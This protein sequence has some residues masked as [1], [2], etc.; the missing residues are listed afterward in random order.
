[1]VTISRKK[2]ELIL[3]K[4]LYHHFLTNSLLLIFLL[5]DLVNA[6]SGKSQTVLQPQLDSSQIPADGEILEVNRSMVDVNL[7]FETSQSLDERFLKSPSLIEIRWQPEEEILPISSKAESILTQPSR[8]QELITSP[9]TLTE[10]KEKVGISEASDLLLP[11]TNQGEAETLYQTQEFQ[12]QIF[13]EKIAQE[14]SEKSISPELERLQQDF[15]LDEPELLTI[16]QTELVASPTVSIVNPIAFGANLGQIFGGFGFQAR[17]RYTNSADGALGVGFG[18][19]DSQR[20]VGFD[21][22]IAV[23]SLLGDDSFERGGIS[24]KMHRLLPESFAI[25]VG[26]ENGVVWGGTDGGQ[27]LY[28]TV[29]KFFPLKDNIKEPFSELTLNFG[30]GGGRFRSEGSIRDDINEVG[31]F[32]SVGI[33]VVEPMS[34]IFEWSGQDLNIGASFMPSQEIPL[35]I[36]LA[37][38]DITGNAGD[39]TRFIMSIGYNYL[40]PRSR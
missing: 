12:A 6:A 2:V 20:A 22:T 5:F 18:L 38:A 19:G 9:L 24:F 25:A 11:S 16:D 33:R 31:V 39:G 17:T 34:L 4:R 15:L 30:L 36:N 28:G 7:A 37:G 32:G 26:Y 14:Q 8:D 10:W 21:V 29:S 1:M 23:L 13:S 27:S 40:F 35:T 3:G